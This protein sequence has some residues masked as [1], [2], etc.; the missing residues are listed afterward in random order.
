MSEQVFVARERELTQLHTFLD[1]ALA[2]QGQV[3]FVTGEAGAGKTALVTEF[4]RRAQDA[5]ADL[6]VAFG[7]CN[8]QTGIGDPYLPFREVL[9]QLTGDVK[10]GAMSEENASRLSGFLRVSGRAIAELGPDLIDIFV[11]GAGLV[12]RAAALVAGRAG[13]LDR[14][15]QLTGHA[16]ASDD[17]GPST[18][19]GGPSGQG[20]E[21]NHLFGQYTNVIQAMATQRPLILVLDDLQWADA[22]SI[23]LLFHLSR[24]IISTNSSGRDRSRILIVG[25]YRPNDLALGRHGKRH[26]LEQVTNELKRYHGDIQVTLGQ[27]GEAERREFVDAFLDARLNCLDEEFRRALFRHARGHPLFTVELLRNM[28]ERGYLVQDD[29]GCWIETPELD[30]ASLPARVEG[31]IGERIGRLEAE[32]Q[33]TLTVASVE[34]EDFTA[35]VLARVQ[36]VDERGL[37]RQLSRE[38]DRQ[39]RL[40]GA[41]GVQ[42]LGPS[43]GSGRRRQRLSLYRFRHNLFQKYLYNH[44]DEGERSFLHEDVGTVLEAL[45]G[46]QTDEIAVQL[47]RHFEEAGLDDKARRYHHQAGARARRQYANE[48]AL[49]HLNRALALTPETD[50]A[51]RYAILLER[52]SV[53]RMQGAREVQ[54]Q[55]LTALE[56]LA[57]MLGDDS[58]TDSLTRSGQGSGQARRAEVALRRANHAELTG[59]FPAAIAAAQKAVALAEPAGAVDTEA[60]AHMQ[61]GRA[62]WRQANYPPAAAQLEQAAQ[63]FHESGGRQGEGRAL[64][65]LGNVAADQGDYTAASAYYEQA[66]RVCREGGDRLG[67]N[68]A[69]NNIGIVSREQGDYSAAMAYYEQ[70][71]HISRKIGDW[72]GE[73][74]L[75]SNLG[76]IADYQG[77]YPGAT[78]HYEQSLRIHREMGDRRGEGHI[79]TNMGLLFHHRGDDAAAI[80]HS[81]QALQITQEIGDRRIEGYALT[82]LGHALA[83]EGHLDEASDAYR[84]ALDMRQE[85]GQHAAATESLAGLARVSMARRDLHQAQSYVEEILGYLE[86]N[87]SSSNSGHGLNGAEEPLR[88]YLTCYRALNANQDPRAAQILTTAHNLLQEQAAKITDE[89]MRRSFLENVP[90][91]REI[92]REWAN[93]E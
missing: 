88:V 75:L 72:E 86:R 10:A 51:A 13:W 34:G 76:F 37:V 53:Y 81:R 8:A 43:T 60:A 55:D 1:R 85:L 56:A 30:W 93:R 4:T 92:L 24:R 19:S 12:T 61:W 40:V 17:T 45:Y 44:L 6:L 67:E 3:C 29:F 41:Q 78:T 73:G 11:P 23:S 9:R 14:L 18:S 69:L 49:T 59:D 42:R 70:A 2:G 33:E 84:Q 20:L 46:N 31:V 32:L 28:Q 26:P 62:L 91:H 79:L 82:N 77:D 22:D 54:Q 63:L 90:A 21:Q 52:E 74:Y 64:N 16:A 48:E 27:E 15:E 89:D 50:V 71:L 25:T 87:I 68:I 35:E 80:E 38:L 58:S 65:S 57:D 5:H 7:D 47:A 36:S 39:H 66:L 83:S